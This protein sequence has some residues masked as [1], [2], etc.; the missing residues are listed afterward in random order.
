MNLTE[1]QLAHL[2]LA[3]HEG[4]LTT[5]EQQLLQSAML[6]NPEI[7][8][9][10]EFTPTLTISNETYNGPSLIRSQLEHLAVYQSEEGHP[11]D[12]LAIG[13]FEGVLSKEEEAYE[14]QLTQDEVYQDFKKRVQLT[15]LFADKQI[16]FPNQELL[17]K[18]A[19]IRVFSFKKYVYPISAAAAVLIA[20]I[21]VHQNG[22]APANI[23]PIQKGVASKKPV[24]Q[25]TNG[26]NMATT[27]KPA[28]LK[29]TYQSV[30][31]V[32][33]VVSQEPRDCIMPL[34]E[35]AIFPEVYAQNGLENGLNHELSTPNPTTETNWSNGIQQA[36]NSPSAFAKEPITVKAF[37][38]QK[39][40]E[41]LFGTAAPTT[42][43][44]LETIARYAKQTVGIPVQ[45]RVEEMTDS[46]KI[47]FQ[48]G[49]FSVE[50]NRVKK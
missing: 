47:V 9:D 27:L 50:R 20:V 39:T 48:L 45:Y 1:A 37:L 21:L 19:P 44:K 23:K 40:N 22:S 5:E 31:H 3:F 11:Y 26:K 4:S 12:K 43:M 25:Q 10:L 2:I 16:F 13:S 32:H 29:N 30:T 15:Q 36:Q 24:L 33:D 41:K 46:E 6:D 35:Q 8:S 18:T 14:A 38:L 49:R 34:Q 28:Q 7:A 42:D 17:F